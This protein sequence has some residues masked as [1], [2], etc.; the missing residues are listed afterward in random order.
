MSKSTHGTATVEQYSQMQ[1]PFA[2]ALAT[3][4]G[5]FAPRDILSAL[6]N[7]GGKLT[8]Y[9]RLVLTALTTKQELDIVVAKE[10][11]GKLP[12]RVKTRELGVIYIDPDVPLEKR[13]SKAK[14]KCVD[15]PSDADL[16]PWPTE[17]LLSVKQKV[18]RR[19]VLYPG[20]E[21]EEYNS[22]QIIAFM[23]E[24]GDEPAGLDDALAIAPTL[25]L[26]WLESEFGSSQIEF[27]A[28][29]SIAT[30]PDGKK[31]SPMLEYSRS[32]TDDD[33]SKKLIAEEVGDQISTSG[34][35]TF[36]VYA[37][38]REEEVVKF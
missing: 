26:K 9:L 15:W 3:A 4:I 27:L 22:E 37:A 32:W 6:S 18:R 24:N 31:Y 2:S 8:R 21:R 20:A 5:S 35:C 25:L 36:N 33:R 38:I 1:T 10:K 14:F 30:G 11:E 19:I 13:I 29:H 23:R 17:N 7:Q 16:K 28:E 34:C 12:L